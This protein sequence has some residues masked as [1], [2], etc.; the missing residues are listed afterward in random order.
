MLK[1]LIVDDE[2]LVRA[3]IRETIEWSDYGVEIIGDAANGLEGLDLALAH[4]PHVIV[5]DVRMPY[6]N[7]LEFLEK[8]KEHDLDCGVIVLSGYDEFQYAQ[9]AL[10]HGAANYLL[11][12]VDIGQLA[13]S[14]Q[15]VGMQAAERQARR[16]QLA[17]YLQ[18]QDAISFQF[19]LNLLYGRLTEP[20]VI[21]EKLSWLGVSLTPG[22]S[23]MVSVL[24]LSADSVDMPIP[25]EAHLA[26][27]QAIRL[28]T[29]AHA[30]T[31]MAVLRSSSAEW[32]VIALPEQPARD[33]A[34]D[35]YAFGRD[36][37]SLL[38]ET[39]G[40]TLTMGYTQAEEPS[41]LHPAFLS[42]RNAARKAASTQGGVLAA[43]ANEK[44]GLR[45]EIREALAYMRLHYADNL[46][47]DDLAE[48]VHVSP[49]HLMHLFRKELDKTFYECLTDFRIEEAKRLLRH[50]P[51]RV[52]EIGLRVGFSDSKY[53]SQIFRKITGMTP[54]DYAKQH[55]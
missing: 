34:S 30:L 31:P 11:K 42:A 6:M 27:E 25:A 1:A 14:V 29:A 43:A 9:E 24:T 40:L 54:S 10:R 52:Y 38:K 44:A 8:L 32:T 35:T 19:W 7:G 48:Q 23:L 41:R 13:H 17:Q 39:A 16:Q 46:T 5:T 3:G 51:Y 33:A 53:F 47:A 45:R 15:Q 2:Y 37:L 4:H 26:V 49:T 21:R 28:K 55:Q 50:S 12:P 36:V 18:E 20:E 22:H